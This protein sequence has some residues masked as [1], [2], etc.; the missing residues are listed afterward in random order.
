MSKTNSPITEFKNQEGFA[1]KIRHYKSEDSDRLC[2]M[3][4][5]EDKLIYGGG[6]INGEKK[7]SS[8]FDKL[9]EKYDD[10]ITLL[11]EDYKD[12]NQVILCAC[13]SLGI[14][15]VTNENKK[16]KV[17]V[18]CNLKIGANYRGIGLATY[19]VKEIENQASGRDIKLLYTYIDGTII[20]YQDLFRNSGYKQLDTVKEANG[21]L[22]T[23]KNV[24]YTKKIKDL[25]VIKYKVI[26]DEELKGALEKNFSN[27]TFQLAS[28]DKAFTNNSIK[29]QVVE[30]EQGNHLAGIL[31]LTSELQTKNEFKRFVLPSSCFENS[32]LKLFLYILS[33][34]LTVLIYILLSNSIEEYSV[35]LCAS[36]AGGFHIATLF[37]YIKFYRL[38]ELF[39]CQK[40]AIG[41]EFFYKS[42]PK[43]KK[44]IVGLLRENFFHHLKI[45][46]Y[47]SVRILANNREKETNMFN[48]DML[49]EY[50]L[51]A[52]GFEGSLKEPIFIDPRDVIQL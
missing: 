29:Y 11:A 2:Q 6:L 26:A 8:S 43:N 14:K 28:D 48:L 36:F 35:L 24:E 20:S 47:R 5:R 13:I 32:Y 7:F 44:D 9:M 3:I 18:V 27:K 37:V 19:L 52:K 21:L 22:K 15:N 31:Q 50:V 17:G 49:G 41:F 1:V 25:G 16:I 39:K 38:L 23:R 33:L 4:S 30:D 42:D 12:Q 45:D 46:G 10:F 40:E 51:M 34:I